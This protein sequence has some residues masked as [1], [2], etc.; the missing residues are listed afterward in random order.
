[1]STRPKRNVGPP[2]PVY[3]PDSDVVFDDD[4]SMDD[5][6]SDGEDSISSGSV[7]GSIHS[8]DEDFVVESDGS[9]E[10]DSDTEESSLGSTTS[11]ESSSTH[12]LSDVGSDLAEVYSL[13][14]SSATSYSYSSEDVEGSSITSDKHVADEEFTKPS[15]EESLA[16]LVDVPRDGHC[17]FHCYSLVTGLSV[18][19]LR[20]FV[21]A[22]LT[23]EHLASLKAIYDNAD[24]AS[25]LSDYGF[26]AHVETLADL[27]RKVMTAEYWGDEM[28][29]V[30]LEEATGVRPFVVDADGELI[31]RFKHPRPARRYLIVRLVGKHYQLAKYKGIES[32]TYDQLPQMCRD[33]LDADGEAS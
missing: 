14:S 12:D 10:P 15:D 26:M 1:M 11:E 29:L 2:K 32:P 25:V 30:A 16:Q 22:Y 19:K 4:L 5:D 9:V 18:K 21:A 13:E 33:A 23:E 31:R 20:R 8:S 7:D 17:L 3:V 6:D 27:R 24:E 28:A